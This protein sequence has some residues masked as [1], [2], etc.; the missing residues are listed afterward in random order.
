MVGLSE[1]IHGALTAMN[2]SIQ[3]TGLARCHP[4]AGENEYLNIYIYP[5]YSYLLAVSK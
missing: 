4:I 2:K 1:V 3:E 5:L